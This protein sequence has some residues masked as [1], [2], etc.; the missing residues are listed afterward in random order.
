[1]QLLQ[2]LA[3]HAAAAPDRIAYREAAGEQRELTY[4][5]LHEASQAFAARIRQRTKPAATV[6]MLCLPNR[7]EYPVAFLGILTAGCGVFPVSPE[8]AEAELIDLAREANFTGIVG[9]PRACHALRGITDFAVEAADVMNATSAEVSAPPGQ[10][11]LLLHSS[12]TTGRPKIVLRDAPSLDAVSANMANAIHFRPEDR[13]LAIVPLCHSYGLEHGLLAPLWAGSTVHLCAGLDMDTVLPQL[14]DA[15]IT[16]FPT[17]PSACEMM[18]RVARSRTFSGLRK[19]YTAGAPLPA[20]VADA[21]ELMFDQRIG[22]LYG[23]TEIGSVA[24]S[25]PADPHFDPK[26]VGQP[27][28]GVRIKIADTTTGDPLTPGHEGEVLI[29]ATSMF[30]GY[31]NQIQCP[32]RD[33]FFPT[34]DLGRLDHHGNLTI[35]G[36]LKLLIEVG[37]LKVNVLEVEETLASHPSVKEAAVVPLRVTETVSR[38]KAIVT[39]RDMN[40]PPVPDDLRKF[41]RDRL[42]PHK[43]PRVIE[44][45]ES[46]PRSATGK[47]L[48]N[49]LE[50]A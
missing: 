8:I 39:P 10:P 47:L 31:L 19:I 5:R 11:R 23:A 7:V 25:D 20:S 33:G 42:S 36:R 37:G 32:L 27:F 48:R 15:A 16:I 24:W 2:R 26:S 41:L 30:R 46:L 29:S 13:V 17:V 45:R 38:L 40:H 35:T 1:M 50:T 6:V 12:G 3:H 49:Q 9:T 22:Q 28:E 43:V 34:G 21:F 18:C 4:A 44:V 14:A